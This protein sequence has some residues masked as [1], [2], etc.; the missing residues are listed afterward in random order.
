M[1]E[2][3]IAAHVKLARTYWHSL[4]RLKAEYEDKAAGRYWGIERDLDALDTDIDCMRNAARKEL[5]KAWDIKFE[6]ALFPPERA[7][8]RIGEEA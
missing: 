8:A 1:G 7:A 2:E 5:R 4:L 3:R 6:L